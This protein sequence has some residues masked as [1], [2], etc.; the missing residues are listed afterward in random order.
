MMPGLSDE[1]A[2][3]LEDRM[4]ECGVHVYSQQG[5]K[6]IQS[7]DDSS[8]EVVCDNGSSFPC[9]MV[10]LSVGVK[11]NSALAKDAGLQ[12]GVKDCVVVNEKLQTSDPDVYAVGDVIE[13]N[14]YVTGQKR[15]VPLAGPANRQGRVV[16][17]VLCDLPSS[18]RGSQGTSVCGMFD[19]CVA[20]T[21]HT[22]RSL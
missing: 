20:M 22:P 9:D 11:P 2:T 5:I 15:H 4:T 12:L 13:V 8:L 10:L 7:K 1:L 16:A 18:F 21:G 19:V 17:D 14:D 6:E 3:V